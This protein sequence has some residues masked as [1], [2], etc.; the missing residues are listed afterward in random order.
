M[1]DVVAA[2]VLGCVMCAAGA[3]K[4]AVGQAWSVE[5][6]SMGAPRFVVPFIPWIEIVSG[7]LLI[8][9]WQRRP[10]AVGVGVLLIVF[11]GLIVSNLSRGRRPHCACFGAWST[12]Q[13]GWGHLVRNAGL[14]ALAVIALFG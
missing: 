9:Q 6:A 8:A 10:V 3:S 14:I 13:L 7:A 1:L 4:I 11:T 2:V 5:A 12:R